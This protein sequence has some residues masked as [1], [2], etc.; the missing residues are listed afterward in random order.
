[1]S[2][3]V[4][5][6]ERD[7]SSEARESLQAQI[8]LAPE[9]LEAEREFRPEFAEV[10][11]DAIERVL[12]GGEDDRG[13]IDVV[14]EEIQPRVDET[15][16]QSKQRQLRGDIEAVEEF[17]PRAAEAFEAVD[18]QQQE[19]LDELTAQAQEGLG[20]GLTDFEQRQLEQQ[21]RG[22]QAARGMG[23]SP[24]DSF[25]EVAELSMANQKR[26]DRN[27]RF[28]SDVLNMRA[29]STVDPFQAILG[30]PAQGPS[31][32]NARISQAS[33]FQGRSGSPEFDPFRNPLANEINSFNANAAFSEDIQESNIAAGITGAAIGAVGDVAS[34]AMMG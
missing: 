2:F 29:A 16:A 33:Q 20:E 25:Q 10:Q 24:S 3:D 32:A 14:A 17:G 4:D 15:M 28:A 21:I 11:R 26:R 8:D 12:L 6:P 34:A 19:L 23:F 13:F 5:A 18:P 7:L 9:R 27:R 30:R 31:Q 22:S 1:M